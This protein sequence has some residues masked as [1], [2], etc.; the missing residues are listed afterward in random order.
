MKEI[1]T[2]FEVSPPVFRHVRLK[3]AALGAT[4]I[5]QGVEEN[6]FFDTP[7]A[8]LASKGISLRLREWR[9]HGVYLT[10]KVNSPK[11]Q[12]G[13]CYKEREEYQVLVDT[14]SSMCGILRA[15]GFAQV[16]QYNKSREH[17]KLGGTHIEL[18]RVCG[19]YFVEIE[20]PR[21]A[22]NKL[23]KTL[24][25][26]WKNATAQSYRALIKELRRK[27]TQTTS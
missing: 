24:G 6:V 1:E 10:L 5:W 8:A 11:K 18:D 17:W 19:R 9:G 21:T 23:V 27:K 3:L 2:R 26:D 15:L 25:L 20:G 14:F 12:K 16:E 4:C 13:K 7:G 22:I